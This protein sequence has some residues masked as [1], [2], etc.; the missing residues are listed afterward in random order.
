MKKLTYF[1]FLILFI[2]NCSK[3][4]LFLDKTEHHFFLENNDA[5]M[6]V[7]VKGNTNSKIFII[8]LHGGPGDGGIRDFG[9]N[10]IFK[11]LESDYAMVYWDQR[12]AGLSQSNCDPESLQVS[13]FVEDIDKLILVLE[14]IYGNDLSLFLL[15][16]SWGATLGLDYLINGTYKSKIKGFVQ[17]DGSHDIPKLFIEQ[18]EIMLFYVEQQI[19]LNNKV[20]EW[21][22]IKDEIS[23]ADPN[24]EEGRITI[25]TNTYKT[26]ELFVAV[27]SV[28]NPTLA[29]SLG[30][31]LRGIFP[32]L[33][34]SNSNSKFTLDL[35][36]YNITEQ[37]DEILTPTAFFWGKFDL[38]HPPSM[39]MDIFTKLGTTEKLLFFFPE[40]FHSPMANENELFQIKV[41]EFVE[42]YK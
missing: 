23:D 24:V 41:K 18:K 28:R 42:I 33:V 31:Y 1:I 26:E 21:Q 13:D 32:A 38:V 25:L 30:S 10:G 27:D 14:D 22:N 19:A 12:C 16:H 20:S 5:I 9:D 36:D 35:F 2:T 17:S 4:E 40:S 6:P 37:L 34:N 29:L 7:Q 3:E 11:K 8:I 15:G 39:A